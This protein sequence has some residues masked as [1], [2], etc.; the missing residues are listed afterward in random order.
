MSRS[1]PAPMSST[2]RSVRLPSI[3]S[4][5]ARGPA[6][7]LLHGWSDSCHAF[8]PLLSHLPSGLRAVSLTQRGHGD[9]PAPA[10]GYDLETMTAD[11]LASMDDAG[12]ERAVLVGHSMGSIVATRLALDSPDRVAGLVLIGAKPSFAD[13]ALDPLYD[14]VRGVEGSM[15]PAFVRE[16]QESTLARPVDPRFLDG[17]VSESLEVPARVW[18]AV[19]DPVLR[20]D[21]SAQL[22]RIRAPALI[23]WGDRDEI[24]TRADQDAL[25]RQLPDARLVVHPGGGHAPHWEDPAAVAADL[26]AFAGLV[27]DRPA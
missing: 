2:T 12:I 6:L 16:F 19:I 25:V 14:A 1:T 21:H 26:A 5:P 23:L 15:D 7:V 17:V 4:G 27:A 18:Q 22:H 10:D 20:A 8:G 11:V 13:P 24:A 9:A 3:A